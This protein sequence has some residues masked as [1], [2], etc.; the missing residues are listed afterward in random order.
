M[1]VCVCARSIWQRVDQIDSR[2]VFFCGAKYSCNRRWSL[3]D[4]SGIETD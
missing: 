2:A 3:I 1:R 4:K